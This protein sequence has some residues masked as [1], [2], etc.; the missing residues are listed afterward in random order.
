MNRVISRPITKAGESRA[1]KWKM[2]TSIHENEIICSQ[3][4]TSVECERKT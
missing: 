4:Y 3:A 1:S 2:Y